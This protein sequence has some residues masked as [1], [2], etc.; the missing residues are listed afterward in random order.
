MNLLV[1]SIPSPSSGVWDLGPIPLR[2]YGICIGLGVIAAVLLTQRRWVQCGHD[3][4]DIATVAT[5]AVPWGVVG[6]RLYHVVTDNQRFRGQWLEAFK[7]WEGGLG[8]WGAV[9]GG[10]VAAYVVARR[11]GY[12][13]GD[14]FYATAPAIPLAQAIGRF[15]NYFNQELFGRPTDLPWALE[16]DPSHRPT[17]YEQFETFHPTFLYEALWNLA[18]VAVVIWVVPRVLPNLRRGY[19]FAAYVFLYTVGRLWIELM[20]IDSANKIFG[21]RLNVWTSLIVGGTAAFLVWRGNRRRS[22]E[23]KTSEMSS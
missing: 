1:S 6:G 15:G 12:D 18:V 3:A 21:V 4:D 17:G 19:H 5:W 7:I 8:V 13:V 16:I 11:R 22:E 23:I 9:A 2:A 14:L 10:G 20:R